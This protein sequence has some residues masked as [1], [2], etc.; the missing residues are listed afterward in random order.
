MDVRLATEADV[1][2]MMTLESQ[3]FVGN[4]DASERVAGFVS[5][6]H[7]R[8]WFDHA[9]AC[10]GVHVAVAD[11]GAITGFI[12]VTA[13]PTRL[14]AESSPVMRAMLELAGTL[15]F[16]GAP[17]AQQRYAIRGPVLVDRAARGRGLYDAF[18]AVT[19]QAYRDRF[20]LAVLFVAADNPTS[21]HT[22]TSK[23]GA[24]PLA[25]F[26]VDD[27]TYHFLAITY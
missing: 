22:T 3:N 12:A 10:E 9:V 8:A 14:E 7:P 13:P 25:T 2:A 6:L 5:T 19:Q 11:D 20:D 4:L 24:T 23:L 17:I 1:S 26:S 16:N 18:N 27:A 15:E 21:L